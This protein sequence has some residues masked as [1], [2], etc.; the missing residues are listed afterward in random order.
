M[1]ELLNNQ[2]TYFYTEETKDINFRVEKLKI[3]KIAILKYEN[4]IC[5]ALKKD[6]Y[7]SEFESYATE[8]G[9]TLGEINLAVKKLRRWAKPQRVK[10]PITNFGA[11]SYIYS[12]PYGVTRIISP[13]N[14]PFQLLMVPL[15]GAIAA[16]KNFTTVT[17]ELGGKSPCIV[18]LL[19]EVV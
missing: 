16:A 10:I 15:I 11:L 17:L 18:F 6:L 1:K 7:K 9:I 3:L 4:D 19:V 12:E 5:N 2:N 14:Y 13:W 8:I